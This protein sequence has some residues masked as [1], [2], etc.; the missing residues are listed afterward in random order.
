MSFLSSLVVNTKSLETRFN[1]VASQG[2]RLTEGVHNVTITGVKLHPEYRSLELTFKSDDEKYHT[3]Y[4]W[5]VQ[6]EYEDGKLTDKEGL[7]KAYYQFSLGLGLSTSIG[8]EFIT[9]AAAN[10]SLFQALTGL[11]CQIKLEQSKYGVMVKRNEAGNLVIVD[12]GSGKFED[13]VKEFVGDQEFKTFK[14][15]RDFI[16]STD[17]ALRVAYLEV[18]SYRTISEDVSNANREA[19]QTAISAAT[20]GSQGKVASIL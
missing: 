13:A 14:E 17:K 1:E 11:Q 15:A 19:I 7:S 6:R 12:A 8:I 16:M 20:T 2:T 9:A 3:Q 4:M 5:L 18:Q 10:T